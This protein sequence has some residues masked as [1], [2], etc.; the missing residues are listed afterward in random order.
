MNNNGVEDTIAKLNG[1]FALTWY[2]RE[3]ETMNMIRNTERTLYTVMSKD[4][5]TMFW[6]SEDWMLIVALRRA[7]IEHTEVAM[8]PPMELLTIP[9]EFG[10]SYKVGPL[11]GI[12]LR[13][14]EGYRRPQNL[15]N[16][17]KKEGVEPAQVLRGNSKLKPSQ[18]FSDYTRYI[19]EEVEFVVDHVGLFLILQFSH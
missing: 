9:I 16:V 3:N 18:P 1:A 10:G 2:D 7:G 17:N 8:L 14:L 19:R 4:R 12:T 15:Y 5:K 11:K 13:K 6:A